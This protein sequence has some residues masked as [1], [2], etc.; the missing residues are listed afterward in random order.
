MPCT[1]QLLDE[2]SYQSTY[3]KIK[4]KHGKRIIEEWTERTDPLKYVIE[5][6]GIAAYLIEMWN[7]LKIVPTKGF[8]DLG[9]GNGLLVH[10]L[11]LEGF[12]GGFGLDVR[13]RKIWTKFK[14]EGTV[15]HEIIIN[16]YCLDVTASNLLNNVDFL[17]GNHSD[18]LTPWIPV[19]AARLGCNFFLLPCCP[20]NFFSKFS[21]KTPSAQQKIEGLNYGLQ[22]QFYNYLENICV[23]LGF[24]LIK[25]RLRIPSRKNQCFIGIIPE[26]GLVPNLEQ[27]INELLFAAK[28]NKTSFVP[29]PSKEE[30]RNCSRLPID[31]R[32]ELTKRIVDYLMIKS[33][34]NING[35]RCSG[36][37]HLSQLSKDVLT[38]NDRNMLSEQDKGIQTF[39]RGQHQTF[40]VNNGNVSIRKWPLVNCDFAAKTLNIRKSDCWF[41][42][43]HPDG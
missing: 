27:V 22:D 32:I 15:L 29:R 11:E 18:E 41:F 4:L 25:D 28:V 20:Y 12:K 39:L 43:F 3:K 38:E 1:I 16:P 8:A 10:L 31:A 33:P 42:K 36:P 2:Q 24:K 19:L 34:Q 40:L 21:K 26:N 14:R 17:I 30:V 37:I 6:C 23:R 7:L 13:S 35:W 5:D 9:C